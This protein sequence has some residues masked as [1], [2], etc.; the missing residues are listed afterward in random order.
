M[1]TKSK[2]IKTFDKELAEILINSGFDYVKEKVNGNQTIYAFER[3]EQILHV[4]DEIEKGSLYSSAE[5]V[6]DGLLYI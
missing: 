4:L 2:F 5:I 6:T 1:G 3:T